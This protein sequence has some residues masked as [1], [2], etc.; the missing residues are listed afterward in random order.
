[1]LDRSPCDG[2]RGHE[3]PARF[4][5]SPAQVVWNEQIQLLGW[6]LPAT[7]EV[8]A[9]FEL[10][11]VY[12]ALRP[13]DRDWKIFAHFDSPSVR[14]NADHE[15]A[16]GWCPTSRWQAGETI[17]DR[18]TARFDHAGRYALG[19]GF[20]AGKA[21]DWVNLSVSAAPAAM[22]DPAQ[23]GVRIADVVVE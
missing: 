11:L 23:R 4:I 20:F 1:V 9:P 22:Q 18:A 5:R 3:L 7:A 14:L 6:S 13:V 10:T 8:G 15:P 19:I 2:A 21:P 12:R 17:V 16:I